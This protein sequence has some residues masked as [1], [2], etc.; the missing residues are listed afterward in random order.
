MEERI[1]ENIV[2]ALLSDLT[3]RRGFRQLWDDIDE[4]IQ[5]QMERPQ[6]R[7]QCNDCEAW[8]YY[9]PEE[10]NAIYVLFEQGSPNIMDRMILVCRKCGNKQEVGISW[11]LRISDHTTSIQPK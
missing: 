9:D 11:P 7:I 1:L 2:N 6:F 4:D 5:C 8:S 3:D 10:Q